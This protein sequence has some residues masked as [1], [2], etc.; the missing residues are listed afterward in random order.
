MVAVS[1]SDSEINNEDINRVIEAAQ[2][3]A[4]P[5]NYEILHVIPSKFIVDNQE[6]IKNPVGMTG[7]RLEVITLIIQNS[8][9]QIK[10]LTKA[11]FHTGLNIDDLVFSLAAATVVITQKQKRLELQLLILVQLPL[12]SLF[13][14]KGSYSMLLS[15]QLVHPIL[16]PILLLAYV[17]QSI[18]LRK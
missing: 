11:I 17:A 10:N 6:D 8:T 18:W 2:A 12:V 15:C 7:I 5:P 16:L 4:V 1:R 3:L 14:K 9:S 13:L